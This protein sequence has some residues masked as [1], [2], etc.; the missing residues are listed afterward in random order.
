M[1]A[2]R[3]P[4]LEVAECAELVQVVVVR[5]FPCGV[6]RLAPEAAVIRRTRIREQRHWI[7]GPYAGVL[8]LRAPL[9]DEFAVVL[10]HRD[11]IGLHERDVPLGF[12]KS[13]GELR[14]RHA[15]MLGEYV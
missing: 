8:H 5:S 4:L 15:A 12:D 7:I 6:V 13:R 14:G 11:E 9:L 2:T 1:Q 3:L 10:R